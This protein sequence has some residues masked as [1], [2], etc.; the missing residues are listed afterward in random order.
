MLALTGV[1]L[2]ALAGPAAAS[3]AQ[4]WYLNLGGGFDHMGNIEV[5]QSPLLDG[6]G[7]KIDKINTGNSALVEGAIGFRFPNRIRFETEVGYTNHS[8]DSTGPTT[9]GEDKILSFLFNLAYDLP[10]TDRW[11][12]TFG[13]G[14]GTGDANEDIPLAGGGHLA[15]GTNQGYMWQA[16]AGFNYSLLDNLDVTVD[17]RYRS[18][19]VNRF[20]TS[21]VSIAP[22]ATHFGEQVRDLNEQVVMFGLRYYLWAAPPPPPPPPPPAPPPPPPPPPSPSPSGG[23]PRGGAARGAAARKQ[24]AGHTPLTPRRR[25]RR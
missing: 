6:N 24:R 13:A 1:A 25:R 3:D 18:L 5:P 23:N 11:D 21:N 19:S 9:G 12:F 17:W 15:T 10:I 4:G 2:V 8:I 22:G 16:L 7:N 20:Y 14:I